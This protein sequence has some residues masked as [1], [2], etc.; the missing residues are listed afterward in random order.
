MNH[1]G[2]RACVASSAALPVSDETAYA[3]PW[4]FLLG[5]RVLVALLLAA[6]C[7]C[8]CPAAA[9]AATVDG[10]TAVYNF[11]P[12]LPNQHGQP[13]P[14]GRHRPA[15]PDR[16]ASLRR[17]HA[18]PHRP[19]CSNGYLMIDFLARD[20]G[21]PLLSPY[22]DRTED[23]T[24]GANFAVAG[25]TAL[26]TTA[27][28]RRG[29]GWSKDLMASTT[30]STQG[31][32]S[33]DPIPAMDIQRKLA[34]SLELLE[35]GGNDVT[36][37]FTTDTYVSPRTQVRRPQGLLLCH[38]NRH[39]AS[40]TGKLN[41]DQ[42]HS[43]FR[44]YG[45]VIMPKRQAPKSQSL[46]PRQELALI[47]N[48][49]PFKNQ[50][51]HQNIPSC[52]GPPPLVKIKRGAAG[53]GPAPLVIAGNFPIGCVP[54]YLAG[55]NV[56]EPAAYDADG[57]L[58]PLNAFAELY[59]AAV[60]AATEGLRRAHPR[61]AAV[62][63]ARGFDPATA[64]C[65]ATGGAYNLDLARFCG[66]AGTTVCADRAR[67]VSWDGVRTDAARVRGH[68][69]AAVPRGSGGLAYPPPIKWPVSETPGSPVKRDGGA[70]S[71]FVSG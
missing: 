47:N 20:L 37:D 10:I 49:P 33:R 34:S 7:S 51:H 61:A 70:I 68:G 24:H 44:S 16:A 23:F 50:V 3:R 67:Y 45:C 2:T 39:N 46:Y 69:R 63:R 71:V 36:P 64:C 55:A 5:R 57:C 48:Q 19:R 56:T 4:L 41:F 59:N 30:N 12:G 27:L 42:A 9:E 32:R 18:R 58:A 40:N 43:P 38:S 17:R 15:A 65:G 35:I 60:R 6:A 53:H 31:T 25:A 66:A 54:S 62:A 52:L 14:R 22:L 29:L 11:G 8:S 13:R 26:N 21:L 28:A 1:T